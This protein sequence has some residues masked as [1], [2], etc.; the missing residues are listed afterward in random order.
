MFT[1]FSPEDHNKL[2]IYVVIHGE[3]WKLLKQANHPSKSTSEYW[4]IYLI[5][6]KLPRINKEEN[7]FHNLIK[8]IWICYATSMID[9]IIM[10]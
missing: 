7:N 2:Q 1:F 4:L 8:V 5:L 9:V 10:D 3:W 6:S